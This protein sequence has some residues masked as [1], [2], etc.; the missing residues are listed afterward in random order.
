MRM[1]ASAKRGTREK[2]SLHKPAR[3][4]GFPAGAKKKPPFAE[5]AFSGIDGTPLFGQ[6]RFRVLV[7]FDATVSLD[8][9]FRNIQAIELVFG[10]DPVADGEIDQL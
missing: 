4:S 8:T 3:F 9:H 6:G 2:G 7:E 5:A 10:L 1:S